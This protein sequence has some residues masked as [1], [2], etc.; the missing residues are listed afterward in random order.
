[1]YVKKVKKYAISLGF[2]IEYLAIHQVS[3]EGDTKSNTKFPAL[4][5]SWDVKLNN[6]SD[7]KLAIDWASTRRYG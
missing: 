2:K 4:E 3:G 1:M 7:S 6:K 5:K